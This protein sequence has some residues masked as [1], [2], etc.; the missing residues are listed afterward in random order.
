M[1]LLLSYDHYRI[2]DASQHS[3]IELFPSHFPSLLE[4]LRNHSSDSLH[5]STL[6]FFHSKDVAAGVDESREIFLSRKLIIA[7]VHFQTTKT[8]EKYAN[9]LIG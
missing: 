8:K 4:L 9:N 2:F 5:L 7:L 3:S 6:A 1:N